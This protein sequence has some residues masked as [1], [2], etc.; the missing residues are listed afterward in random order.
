ML[1][2]AATVLGRPRRA[3][4]RATLLVD[5]ADPT[6]D[7]NVFDGGGTK[8]TTGQRKTID[9]ERFTVDPDARTASG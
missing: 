9:L 2:L 8:P 6:G 5:Q 4:P 1:A 3:G 7:V